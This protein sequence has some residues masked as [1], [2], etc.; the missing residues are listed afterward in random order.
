MKKIFLAISLL[1]ISLWANAMTKEETEYL[2]EYPKAS[3]AT[4]ILDYL[5]IEDDK[6][7]IIDQCFI[8][9]DKTKTCNMN[10]RQ[11][12]EKDT[13]VLPAFKLQ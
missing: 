3:K 5:F 2:K 4:L 10:H 12:S 7:N 9:K 6:G 13:D 11:K 1:Q 8:A